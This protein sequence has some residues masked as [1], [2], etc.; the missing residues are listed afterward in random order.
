MVIR[1]ALILL[2]ALASRAAA[3]DVKLM[4]LYDHGNPVVGEMVKLRIRG[5]YDLTVSLEDMQFPNSPDYDWMQIARDDWHKERVNGRLLQIFERV[6][7]VFPRR[8]G[9]VG[10]G[11]LTHRLTYVTPAGG[12]AEMTV[13]AP[14][15]TLNVTPFPGGYSPLAAS[16]LTLTD[17]LSAE[18]GQLK[19][20]EVLTRRVTI[21][22]LGTLAHYL[23]PRPEMRQPWMIS[24][25][26]PEERETVL[27]DAGPVARVTWEWQMRPHTGEPAI[28]PGTGFPWFDTDTR[29]IEI[30]PLQPIPFGFA[31]FGSN[32]DAASDTGAGSAVL[33][34]VLFLAAFLAGLAA[35]AWTRAPRAPGPTMRSLRRLGPSPARHAMREA[36]DRQDLPALR[37][38]VDRHLRWS[39]RWSDAVAELDRQLYAAN[40]AAGFD[41]TAWLIRFRASERVAG[42]RG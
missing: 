13:T 30:A 21:E 35:L 10:I 34:V 8:D 23:P 20:D 11:P 5:E 9:A 38:A 19:Q 12:R 15:V 27:T 16:Q 22:A 39:G 42:R 33:S 3:Q 18:P 36:A 41:A 40:P 31:G 17:Q 32:F 4:I 26:A 25:T 37:A 28:L 7:A 14:A 24:F 1:L 6:V 29:H 2:L